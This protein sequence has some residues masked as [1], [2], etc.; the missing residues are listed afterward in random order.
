M[1][2]FYE[3][4]LD[5]IADGLTMPFPDPFARTTGTNCGTGSLQQIS[6]ELQARICFSLPASSSST[7]ANHCAL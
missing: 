4:A 7:S 6:A 1:A 5:L 2:L 3:G